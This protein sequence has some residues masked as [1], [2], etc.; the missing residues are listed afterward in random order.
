MP[1]RTD[2]DSILVIGSGPDRHRAGLRVRLL[3]HPGLPGA[4]GGGLPGDP[5]QLQP[6]DDHDR[7]GVRRR[8]LHR[9][10]HPR[11][12]GAGDRHRASRRPAG[13]PGRADRPQRR[14]RAAR[15]RG[16][17][18]VRRRADRRLHRGHPARREP[19]AV[20]GDRARASTG[21]RPGADPAEWRGPQPHLP[22]DG[23]RPG[24][25]GRS[26]LPAGGPAQLH[27]GRRRLRLRPRRGRSS[28]D[29]RRRAGRQPDHR[30]ADRGVDPR[31]EGVRARGHARP[32]RQRGDRL[33]DREPRPDG[34]AHR[35]L[36]HRRPGDDADRP[37]VPADARRG[38]RHHPRRRRGHRRLQHPVRDRPGRPAG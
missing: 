19:R 3:R 12:R 31:L 33:L 34:R 35:R 14:R 37:R 11:V 30:G 25:R 27:H 8:H 36:D 17:G 15:E 22:L 9:A 20:Q 4:A 7:P 2:I 16:A 18:E 26:R 38:H 28:P 23:R 21:D 13:H 29:R 5:G 6:G 24:R 32:G 1:K 10:D